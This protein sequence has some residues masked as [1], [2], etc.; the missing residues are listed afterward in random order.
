MRGRRLERRR[1][2]KRPGCVA[3]EQ[4]PGLWNKAWAIVLER[5]EWGEGLDRGGE[6]AERCGELAVI[7]CSRRMVL[8][9]SEKMVQ[10]IF[11]S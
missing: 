1:R 2:R 8:G 6:G 10:C 11:V 9:E 5:R 3:W 7:L 4:E